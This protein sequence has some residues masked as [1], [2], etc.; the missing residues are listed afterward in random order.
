M[1]SMTDILLWA[2]QGTSGAVAG[3][4]TNKY[5]VN[6]L[7]KE[8]TPFRIGSKVILPYKFG[9]VIKNRKVQFVEELSELVE[10]D[11]INGKTIKPE[12]NSD[13]FK[14]KIHEVS[15]N[16][17]DEY[18][19]KSFGD[20]SFSQIDGF[21]KSKEN[22]INFTQD[23]VKNHI[24]ELA[25]SVAQNTKLS[26]F[27]SQEEI[28]SVTEKLFDMVIAECDEKNVINKF[29]GTVYDSISSIAV[30]EFLTEDAQKCLAENVKDIFDELIS[31]L[32]DNSEK[33][34]QI[35]N[36]A[37]EFSEIENAIDK[38]EVQFKERK[39]SEIIN[40]EEVHELSRVLFKNTQLYL[41]EN[42]PAII[43]KFMMSFI[44]IGKE[45]DYTIYD[46]LGEE[47]GGKVTSFIKEKLPLVMPYVSEWI[48][49]NKD[50]LDTVI[51]SSIDEAIGN[52][53]PN[54]KKL[55]ISKVREFFLDNISAK[56]QVIEKIVSYVDSYK[57]DDKAYE[58]L[59]NKI[60]KFLKETKIRD[61]ILL[62]EEKNLIN[63][64][65][66]NNLCDLFIKEY[67]KHGE[68][69]ISEVLKSL[70]SRK[71]GSLIKYDFKELF[72]KY[73]KQRIINSALEN[74]V[75]IK[76]NLL[77]TFNKFLNDLL[78][79]P[80]GKILPSIDG[81]KTLKS[82]LKNNENTLKEKMNTQ[83]ASYIEDF[84]LYDQYT[85]NKEKIIDEI[86]SIIVD[87]EKS[88]LD[89]LSD[90]SISNIIANIDNKEG[91]SEIIGS[92][93]ISYLNENSDD[94]LSG[95]V[96]NVVYDNLIQYDEDEICELAQRFMGNELKPL[97]VFGGILG[98]IAG[99]IFG[100][101]FSNV[102]RFGFYESFGQGISSFVLMGVIGVITNVIAI[103]MLFK[104]YTKNKILSKIPLLNKFALGYIPAHKE[105]LSNSIGKV[106]D[107]DILNSSKIQDVL[108]KN[109]DNSRDYV[110]SYF[111]NSNYKVIMDLIKNKKNNIV[112]FIY[113]KLIKSISKDKNISLLTSKV[114]N[115]KT[116]SVVSKN[117]FLSIAHKIHE[118]KN[119]LINSCAEY[120]YEI[121]KSNND[122][123][124]KCDNVL[125]YIDSKTIDNIT[126]NVY[127]KIVSYLDY[128]YVNNSLKNYEEDYLKFT[129][130]KIDE[131]LSEEIRNTI[132]DYIN[133]NAQRFIFD[134]LKII[135]IS[136]VKQKLSKEIDG[137]NNIG[138]LLDGKV[139]VILNEN[140]TKVTDL[141]INKLNSVLSKNESVIADKV[142]GEVN[143][144][145]NFFEKIAY[146]MAGGD[147]IVENCVSVAVNKKVPEFINTKVYEISTLIQKSLDD[148]VYPMSVNDLK[149]KGDELN[150]AAVLNN[151]F[152]NAQNSNL[153]SCEINNTCR[154]ILNAT[155]NM[156]VS[157]I[158]EYVNLNTVENVSMKF[159][160][161][162]NLILNSMKQGV[163]N[164]KSK[165]SEYFNN[166]LKE[167][168]LIN[169]NRMPMN[170]LIN[171]IKENDIYYA[172]NSA[173]KRIFEDETVIN[174][175]KVLLSDIYE[176]KLERTSVKE[177]CGEDKVAGSIEKIIINTLSN[178]D[179]L[180]KLKVSLNSLV[181]E[182]LDSNFSFISNESKKHISQKILFGVIDCIITN[183]KELIEAVNLKDVTV[184]QIRVMDSKEIHEL[185]LS[186]AGTFFKKLYAYGAFGAF[187]GL[188]LYLPIIWAVKE[189]ASSAVKNYNNR[190]KVNNDDG[191][192]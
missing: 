165:L 108:L 125:Q 91:I 55:I 3:Y 4:I 67:E 151:L 76:E 68:N 147:A 64:G 118:K 46:L 130:K 129:D 52:M 100:S 114:G 142:K 115:I 47:F 44:E 50:E 97:S 63:D 81:S 123:Q 92:E 32:L 170:K 184:K 116:G 158:L 103:T 179:V 167:E 121:M 31:T 73:I 112:D 132:D 146:S 183:S 181:E 94:L 122:R 136:A 36:R 60:V 160:S 172:V 101:F 25:E 98:L 152:E 156:K 135:V 88:T 82:I 27:V 120:L 104:P 171:N 143:N 43:K 61:I 23:K 140:L 173:G 186:F 177:L 154:S 164:N 150:V 54:I 96:K 22:I 13:G 15:F 155:Y 72:D 185:F 111:K 42:G 153:L 84:N 6:M 17:V 59:F 128:D 65:T 86:T 87:Y 74:R 41:N 53:D 180:Y 21:N 80:A 57:M 48:I 126:N 102:N 77:A 109:K 35:I 188:N 39:I 190:Y 89:K 45:T 71:I 66:L 5:A 138:S 8:Y 79:T 175:F 134:D 169:L 148:V 37:F 141:L 157:S 192:V 99:L 176:D 139:K 144:N 33:V 28:N 105:N 14:R 69:L 30:R 174:E 58:E 9:G 133:K 159:S 107:D 70:L 85:A 1:L 182:T 110:I 113:K 163:E 34:S 106:I 18:L 83:F 161:E 149:L 189:N 191:I 56:N 11:I 2:L 20:M 29:T 12:L 168:I 119:E 7:F 49:N 166:I 40:D 26:S 145:L 131:L 38:F 137:E 124:L 51:E 162:I 178:E 90:E 16:L 117:K 127:E 19:K 24:S 187:F 78:N 95:R 62:L 10:R 93:V 75:R